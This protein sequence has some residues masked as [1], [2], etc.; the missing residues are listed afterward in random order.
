[1]TFG[2]KDFLSVANDFSKK[3]L[4]EAYNRTGISRAYY[5]AYHVAADYANEKNLTQ[6]VDVS[7]N[8]LGTHEQVWRGL[9]SSSDAQIRVAGSLGS[10]LKATRVKADYRKA[11]VSFSCLKNACSQAKKI[12]ESIEK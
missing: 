4:G 2:W 11:P 8:P 12:I 7:G 10:S 9:Q 3:D 5:A 1:M 6:K